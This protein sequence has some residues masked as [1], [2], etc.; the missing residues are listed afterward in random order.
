MNTINTL[1]QL[2]ETGALGINP[3]TPVTLGFEYAEDVM[4]YNDDYQEDV[5]NNSDIYSMLQEFL[6]TGVDQHMLDGTIASA[7]DKSEYIER[8]GYFIDA[9]GDEH[10]FDEACQKL[11]LVTDEDAD[12]DG[13]WGEATTQMTFIPDDISEAVQYDYYEFGIDTSLTQYDH[14]RGCFTISLDL[15]TTAGA[16][17]ETSYNFSGFRIT[18]DTEVASLTLK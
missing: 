16:L 6:T 11:G 3:D 4:H 12:E 14:K 9:D 1:R 7:I 5:F 18:L 2:I 10:N 8:E 17:L 15:N 13:N